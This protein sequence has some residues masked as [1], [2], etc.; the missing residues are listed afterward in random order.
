MFTRGEYWYKKH[1]GAS[2][3][4]RILPWAIIMTKTHRVAVSTMAKGYILAST[5]SLRYFIFSLS[6]YIHADVSIFHMFTREEFSNRN[7]P[8]PNTPVFWLVVDIPGFQQCINTINLTVLWPEIP[9]WLQRRKA[10]QPWSKRVRSS[11]GTAVQGGQQ[12][13]WPT[14]G[15]F[16]QH[17][18]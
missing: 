4:A 12:G 13:D 6:N 17:K 1:R 9:W 16:S 8:N 5:L 18:R 11:D 7:T 10:P 3:R 2:M 14:G 15:A